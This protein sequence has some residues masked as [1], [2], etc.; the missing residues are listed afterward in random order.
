MLIPDLEIPARDQCELNAIHIH[1]CIQT[2]KSLNV[3]VLV[4]YE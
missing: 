1:A 4:I 3:S 2:S